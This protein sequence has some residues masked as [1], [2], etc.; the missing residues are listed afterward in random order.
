[1]GQS[2]VSSVP[3]LELG[4]L[5]SGFMDKFSQPPYRVLIR[6]HPLD[7]STVCPALI[8]SKHNHL[9]NEQNLVESFPGRLKF[10]FLSVVVAGSLQQLV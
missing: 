2:S 8:S 10:P 1:M 6:G 5:L 7:R 9:G 4:Q 3:T